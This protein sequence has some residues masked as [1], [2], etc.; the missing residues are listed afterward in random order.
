MVSKKTSRLSY[1]AVLIFLAV[2]I[3]WISLALMNQGSFLLILPG[4]ISLISA[5]LI[6]IKPNQLVTR[7]LALSAGLYN[8]VI[9]LYHSYSA[10][11]LIGS[12]FSLFFTIAAVGYL[13]GAGF[14]L[15]LVL[16]VSGNSKVFYLS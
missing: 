12:S 11:S 8:L 6:L 2:G 16:R 4:F 10:F 3:L 7:N 15:F 1:M 13:L 5:G 9:L 14:F